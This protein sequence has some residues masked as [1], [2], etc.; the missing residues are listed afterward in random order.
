MKSLPSSSVVLVAA[1]AVGGALAGCRTDNGAGDDTP[2][3]GSTVDAPDGT[4]CT[5]LTPRSQALESF[6]GPT[7]LQARMGALIDSAKT[8]LD[9]QMY[10]WTVKELAN[11][12]VAAKQRG[13]TV[14]V[15]LDPDELGNNN[16]EPI[17]T[18]GGVDWKNATTLYTYSH[19]KYIIVDK[20]QAAIMSMN[21]NVDAMLNERNY[22]VI[23]KDP[24]DVADMQ[25]IFEYDWKMANGATG[26]DPADLTCTRLIVSP[27]N[28]K[29][30]ILEHIKSATTTLD[31]EVMYISE[32]SVRTAITDAK[33][34]GVNVR[35]IIEDPMDASVPVFKAAGIPVKQPPSSI[36]LHS[37][38]ITAD[39]VAFV[40]SEN[41]SFTSL[42][43]N[44]EVGVLVFE[45]AAF[46][47]IKTQFDSDWNVSTT[48]P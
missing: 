30:R 7:G 1:L 41:M 38:L 48:I 26:L 36:Y 35:V 10:L 39:Q 19:A 42:A 32:A 45:P 18:S 13:V 2:D 40:G 29:Q 23:D 31:V 8:S 47:P 4:G 21:F 33:T 25:R 20:Q 5:A 28:S 16:V 15:I 9:I 6:V 22:G 46:A 24:E 27:T 11:K 14:R 37:K 3:G 12:V 44:R 34:R 17:F 43:K